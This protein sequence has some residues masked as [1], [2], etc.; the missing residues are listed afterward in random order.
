MT[1]IND[2]VAEAQ[3]DFKP[4]KHENAKEFVELFSRMFPSGSIIQ[5]YFSSDSENFGNPDEVVFVVCSALPQRTGK[6]LDGNCFFINYRNPGQEESLKRIDPKLKSSGS[7]P[8]LLGDSSGE[9]SRTFY[10]EIRVSNRIVGIYLRH[11]GADRIFLISE[12]KTNLNL[13]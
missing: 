2:I 5:E 9:N 7:I 3:K 13:K 10:S 1:N 11:E 6:F 8:I 12:A 4:L